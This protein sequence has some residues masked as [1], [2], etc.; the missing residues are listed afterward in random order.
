MRRFEPLGGAGVSAIS[1]SVTACAGDLRD[2]MRDEPAKDLVDDAG[3][4]GGEFLA[5]R[6]CD[7]DDLEG[8]LW[9]FFA[10]HR[11]ALARRS[12]GY[13]ATAGTRHGLT[14]MHSGHASPE[15]LR[16]APLRAYCA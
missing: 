3:L 4:F 13:E 1:P 16:E 12:P 15:A 5:P 6:S 9:W 11:S 10:F 7:M 2:G 8:A 14:P